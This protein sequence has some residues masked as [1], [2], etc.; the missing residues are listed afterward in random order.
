MNALKKSWPKT[1]ALSLA[2]LAVLVLGTWV[3]TPISHAKT[4]EGVVNINT[5]SPQEL[6]LLPG[7]GQAKAAAI[8]AARQAKPFTS[9]EDLQAVKGIGPKR[10]EAMSPHV[11]FNGPTTAKKLN[12]KKLAVSQSSGKI[13]SDS[14]NAPRKSNP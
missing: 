2:A 5:A 8:V 7:I 3:A 12:G 10:L 13:K 4:I 11:S 6:T 14:L 9:L 1:W